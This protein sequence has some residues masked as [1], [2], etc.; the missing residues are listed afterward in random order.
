MPHSQDDNLIVSD[1]VYHNVGPRRKNQLS[2][3]RSQSNTTAPR[4]RGEFSDGF[5]DGGRHAQRSLR[6]LGANPFDN[7]SEVVSCFGRPTDL[8]QERNI[9]SM[10]STTSS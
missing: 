9:F 5:V 7:S 10:R 4:G 2:T 6:R 3:I 1:F 8:H